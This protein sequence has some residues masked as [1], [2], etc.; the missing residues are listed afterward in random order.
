MSQK[1]I[2]RESGN[3][4]SRWRLASNGRNLQNRGAGGLLQVQFADPD[5]ASPLRL[6]KHHAVARNG[7]ADRTRIKKLLDLGYNLGRFRGGGSGVRAMTGEGMSV[8]RILS[9]APAHAAGHHYQ[10]IRLALPAD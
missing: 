4:L 7:Q 1:A 8:F 9:M 3:R 2:S 6:R 10:R 5:I